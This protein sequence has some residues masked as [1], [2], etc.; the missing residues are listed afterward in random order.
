M[1][2]ELTGKF[3]Y[4]GGYDYR[5]NPNESDGSQEC[6][7]MS[8]KEHLRLTDEL[9]E[10]HMEIPPNSP[11]IQKDRALEKIRKECY[12]HLEASEFGWKCRRFWIRIARELMR[13]YASAQRLPLQS[14]VV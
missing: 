7:P 3:E 11:Q 6:E 12:C 9:K 2:G 14:K 8:V 10:R 4:I 13:G 1:G 5:F